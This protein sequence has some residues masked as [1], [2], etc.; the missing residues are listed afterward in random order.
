MVAVVG[1]GGAAA[2]PGMDGGARA[3]PI[4]A[5]GI[6]VGFVTTGVWEGMLERAG[7]AAGFVAPGRATAAGRPEFTGR[8]YSHGQYGLQVV[9]IFTHRRSGLR[10]LLDLGFPRRHRVRHW[11][12]YEWVFSLILAYLC[13]QLLGGSPEPT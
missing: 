9:E 11:T 2:R 4:A 10:S 13:L 5:V 3:A 8:L 1:G 7:G 12:V 6:A